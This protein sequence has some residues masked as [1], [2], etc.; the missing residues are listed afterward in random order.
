MRNIE[1][2]AMSI[3][4][5]I[6]Q[7]PGAKSIKDLINNLFLKYKILENSGEKSRF[8]EQYGRFLLEHT[9]LCDHCEFEKTVLRGHPERICC[10][11]FCEGTFKQCQ[12]ENSLQE[13]KYDD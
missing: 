12:I 5:Y 6:W 2:L 13:A 1:D 8:F 3:K 11:H 7:E 9:T 4:S 10:G